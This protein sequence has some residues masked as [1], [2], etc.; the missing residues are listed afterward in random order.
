MRRQHVTSDYVAA[1]L[2]TS[3]LFPIQLLFMQV[4]Y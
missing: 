3:T 2:V 1:K 4:S